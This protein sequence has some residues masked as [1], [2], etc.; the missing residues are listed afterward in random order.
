MHSL[1][2]DEMVKA[3]TASKLVII[4]EQIRFLQQQAHKVL[5]EASQSADLHQAACNFRKLPGHVYHL[6]ERPSGQRYFSM[7]SPE[8]SNC[9]IVHTSD[10]ECKE[11]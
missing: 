3:T 10:I 9:S 6:Y 8:V 5:W 4:A 2:A 11:K 7:L 1:Q